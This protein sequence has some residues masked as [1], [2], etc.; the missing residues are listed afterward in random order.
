MFS[1]LWQFFALNLLDHHS[2]FFFPQRSYLAAVQ[3]CVFGIKLTTLEATNTVE[4]AARSSSAHFSW[5]G[6]VQADTSKVQ[7]SEKVNPCV[8][9]LVLAAPSL[10][11]A[12]A[13]AAFTSLSLAAG[14]PFVSRFC[15]PNP[16]HTH[17]RPPPIVPKMP[18]GP[19][20][21]CSPSVFEDRP[22]VKCVC[23]MV[24]VGG[25]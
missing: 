7:S 6:Q 4:N 10:L 24:V 17:T 25:G 23:V 5:A 22:S 19:G 1:S 12:P 11:S 3:P 20:Q 18:L 16:T 9:P 14:T 15:T 21:I 13:R 2:V 8:L